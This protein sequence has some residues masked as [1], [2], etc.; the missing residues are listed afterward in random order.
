MQ[1]RVQKHL[2]RFKAQGINTEGWQGFGMQVGGRFQRRGLEQMLIRNMIV[3]GKPL[4]GVQN[5]I[6]GISKGNANGNRYISM[7][8]GFLSR[9]R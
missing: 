7:A 8:K 1:K 5:I 9:I 6:N 2:E 4:N 3:D